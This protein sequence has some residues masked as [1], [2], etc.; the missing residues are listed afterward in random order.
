MNECAVPGE[1][2]YSGIGATLKVDIEGGRVM[3]IEDSN[4]PFAQGDYQKVKEAIEGKNGLLKYHMDVDEMPYD[5]FYA[6]IK[7]KNISWCWT[8]ACKDTL[9]CAIGSY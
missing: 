4:S 7:V 3:Y 6:T 2:D 1:S 5:C 8:C 9:S